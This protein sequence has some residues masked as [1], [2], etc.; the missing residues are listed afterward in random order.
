[1]ILKNLYKKIKTIPKEF[2]TYLMIG[3]CTFLLDYFL[4]L[5]LLKH[6]VSMNVSK[7]LSSFIAVIFNYI[8]NSRFNFGGKNTMNLKD[9]F[10]YMSIYAFLILIHVIINRGFYLVVKEEHLAVFLA[11]CISLFINYLSIRKF[12]SYTKKKNHVIRDC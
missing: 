9:V 10:L 8:L 3:S 4:Y 12:F 1:M 7:G 5:F 6:G 11:M 2:V